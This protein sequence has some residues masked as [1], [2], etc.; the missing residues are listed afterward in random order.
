MRETIL[1]VVVSYALGCMV[2]AY[3]I[4]RMRSGVDVRTLGSGNAGARN[5]LRTADLPS[6]IATFVVDATK[7][8]VATWLAPLILITNWASGLALLCVV[9]GHLWPAQLGFR[10]G[11]GVATTLGGLV[12][13]DWNPS[14]ANVAFVALTGALVLFAHHPSYA[15]RSR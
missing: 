6:A 2:G 11:K 15:Y 1:V 13:L 9:I 10:G 4:M 12:M 3:Y 5:V 7:G 8:G 14:P